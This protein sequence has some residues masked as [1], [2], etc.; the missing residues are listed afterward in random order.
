MNVLLRKAIIVDETSPHNGEKCDILI[1]NG[2]IEDIAPSIDDKENIKIISL[3]NLHVSQ[4]WFDSSVSFGEP[5]HEE[6]ETVENGLKTA[7]LSGY[8][9][10]ALNSNC[11]PYT[12]N[13]GAVKYLKS[14]AESNAVSVY[15][16]GSLTVGSC[17][18]DLSE[19]FDMTNEGAISFYDY[20]KPI[21]NP[22]LLK[23]ALQYVQ[24]FNGLVQSFPCDS[25]VA[26]NGLM[27][28][29]VTSTLLGLKGIPALAEELQ[30]ARDLYLLEYTGGRLHIPT[31]STKNAIKLIKNAKKKGLNVTCSVAIANLYLTDKLLESFDTNCKLLPPLRTKPDTK[32]LLKAVEE[33]V[34]DGVTSDHDPIDIEHKKIEFEH[35]LFGSIGLESCFGALNELAG[36]DTTIKALTKLK[37][38]FNI[39]TYS[40]KKGTIASITLFNPDLNWTFTEEDILS[41]SKNSVFRG[42]KM[43]GIAYGIYA[44]KKLAL[45]KR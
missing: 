12:D 13:K 3:E 1:L 40:I 37:T 17:G 29:S 23:L 21:K 38:E 8:A 11:L 34:I 41:S 39:P 24:G 20:K 7:A 18:K 9:H 19:M 27:N 44:N 36:I 42:Q 10:I 22:N 4:S 28:E 45:R 31:I 43:K 2:V 30:I 25:S 32:A 14:L 16:I 5:G 35:A 33:G 15:P 26:L 6:R